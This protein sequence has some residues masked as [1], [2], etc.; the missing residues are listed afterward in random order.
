MVGSSVFPNIR[1]E[2]A[3]GQ[4]GSGWPLARAEFELLQISRHLNTT[5]MQQNCMGHR[6]IF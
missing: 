4:C 1:M 6:V 2:G 5:A 3:I